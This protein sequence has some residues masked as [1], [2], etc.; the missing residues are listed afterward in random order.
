MN[1]IQNSSSK[2][3][4][5][6]AQNTMLSEGNKDNGIIEFRL[7]KKRPKKNVKTYNIET[8]QDI[9]DAVNSKNIKKFIREFEIVLRS[10][11]LLKVLHEANIS[12]GKYTA[13]EV[14]KIELPRFTWI[15]D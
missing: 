7:Q 13:E 2:Q 11:L 12:E 6:M 3:P 8:V 4:E 15:D 14:G 10:G 9:F 5:E 1:N